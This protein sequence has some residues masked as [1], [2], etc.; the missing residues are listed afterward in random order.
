M[1][2][3][4]AVCLSMGVLSLLLL[5]VALTMAWFAA[6]LPVQQSA[7]RARTDFAARVQATRS[8][9]VLKAV[10]TDIAS[11]YDAQHATMTRLNR[12]TDEL[13]K[14][15][16]WFAAAWAVGTAAAFFY[17]F[18]TIRRAQAVRQ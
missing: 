11:G 14:R 17:V 5:V 10:C 12:L 1:S 15:I 8:C 9:E 2:G 6:Q 4:K 18:R 3:A 7:D 16:A 13:L